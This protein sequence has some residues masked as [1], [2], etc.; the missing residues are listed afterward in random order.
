VIHDSLFVIKKRIL[1][2]TN[3]ELRI[4]NYEFFGIVFALSENV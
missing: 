3:Y 1:R 2:I 4:T